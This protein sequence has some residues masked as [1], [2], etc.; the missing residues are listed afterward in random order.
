MINQRVKTD[1]TKPGVKNI[2]LI[3][4]GSTLANEDKIICGQYDSKLS[5][6]GIKETVESKEKILKYLSNYRID[7]FYSSP[8][9]RCLATAS[10]LFPDHGPSIDNRILETNTG[11]ASSLK[12]CDFLNDNPDYKYEGKIYSKKYPQGESCK[13]VFERMSSFIDEKIISSEIENLL[14]VGHGGTLAHF[15]FILLGIN[16]ECYPGIKFKNNTMLHFQIDLVEKISII[17]NIISP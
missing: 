1:L 13:D 12:I 7:Q 6:T 9:S 5:E 15:M 3:R 4:H 10:I 2:F 14:I 16:Y 8:L 11:V 17:R